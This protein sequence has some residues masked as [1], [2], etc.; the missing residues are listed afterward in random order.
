MTSL[1]RRLGRTSVFLLVGA[2]TLLPITASAAP[3][4]SQGSNIDAYGNEN[5]NAGGNSGNENSN[6][7]GNSG[8]ENSNAGGNSGNENSENGNGPPSITPSGVVPTEGGLG[9]VN[10]QQPPT[11]LEAAI[12]LFYPQEDEGGLELP[13]DEAVETAP[14][15]T[16]SV[17]GSVI[18]VLGPMISPAVAKVV[19]APIVVIEALIEAMAAAG[20]AVVIPFI[21]GAVVLLTPGLRRKSLDAALSGISKSTDDS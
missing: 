9:S 17:S 5:S 21:A 15:S 14:S 3:I 7:G 16:G 13:A 10:A 12:V 6:A 4:Q 11:A 20:Q 18:R 1:K 8:N 19:A 2:L